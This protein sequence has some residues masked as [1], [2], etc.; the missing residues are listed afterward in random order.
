MTQKTQSMISP[1]LAPQLIPGT[2]SLPT[3]G[4][5]P[6][7][8]SNIKTPPCTSSSGFLGPEGLPTAGPGTSS[9]ATP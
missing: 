2:P 3:L 5:L 7:Q 6:T 4:F 9:C 8:N 1:N